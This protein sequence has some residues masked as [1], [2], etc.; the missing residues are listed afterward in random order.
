MKTKITQGTLVE[1][2]ANKGKTLV[3]E[4]G[5]YTD[6]VCVPST[7]DLTLIKEIDIKDIDADTILEN[8]RKEV[9]DKISAY[10][11]S[12]NVNEFYAND[13]SFWIPRETRV[14]LQ[15]STEILLKNG[16]ETTTLWEG[17][18]K[19]DIQC[20][21]L[22]Q[23]LD[24]LEIYALKCFNITAEHKANIMKME[25]IEEIENYDYTVGYPEKLK[26]EL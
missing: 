11:I 17:V 13:I 1:V 7:Y 15:N 16:I 8:T 12:R 22:L 9:L 3:L 2:S 10:D 26:F 19:F 23:M 20:E 6:Y 25:T 4:D 14:S 24:A 5:T 18:I 21:T